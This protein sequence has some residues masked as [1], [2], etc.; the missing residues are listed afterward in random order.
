[1]KTFIT[2]FIIILLT[3]VSNFYININDKDINYIKY[4][5]TKLSYEDKRRTLFEKTKRNEKTNSLF[6][7][8]SDSQDSLKETNIKKAISLSKYYNQLSV[9]AK[10]L[11]SV[12]DNSTT[13]YFDQNQQIYAY[14]DQTSNPPILTY[15][16]PSNKYIGFDLI[17]YVIN[18]FVNPSLG[19]VY[20]LQSDYDVYIDNNE[21][22]SIIFR[23]AFITQSC[24]EGTYLQCSSTSKL[25]S[26]SWIYQLLKFN[27]D[28]TKI[29]SI[30]G[31]EDDITLDQ[32]NSNIYNTYITNGNTI[33]FNN[34]AK[35][36]F[37]NFSGKNQLFGQDNF[38]FRFY[39]IHTN[40]T[41]IK[42]MTKICNE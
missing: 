25:I 16:N 19:Y 37:C 26:F 27:N 36:D 34:K 5:L 9:E 31:F 39:D 8:S 40:I 4:T 30:D 29:I 11:S 24:S 7:I 2:F 14:L 18:T 22:I 3:L 6:S 28:Y 32:T 38:K 17:V 21:R 41:S 1:M 23:T 35:Q 20:E 10:D 15:I 13:T 12:L 33:A 42:S